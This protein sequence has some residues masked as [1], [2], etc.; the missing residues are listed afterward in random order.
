MNVSSNV[1]IWFGTGGCNGASNLQ[2]RSFIYQIFIRYTYF[3]W[4]Y[5]KTQTSEYDIL[6]QLHTQ[7]HFFVCLFISFQ[8]RWYQGGDEKKL[9]GRT[10]HV[11]PYNNPIANLSINI[12]LY[13]YH[14]IQSI[15]VS[16]LLATNVHEPKWER[17]SFHARADLPNETK[18][19]INYYF[20]FQPVSY[21]SM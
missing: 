11:V 13:T 18:N 14:W 9:T 4:Q 7:Q 5:K 3:S 6:Y 20:M 15:S 12:Y 10:L 19:G 16:P 1:T 17:L 2:K 8:E 21:S